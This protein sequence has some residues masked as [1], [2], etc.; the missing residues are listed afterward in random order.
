MLPADKGWVTVVIDKTDTLVN[1][2][3]IYEEL[4][5]DPTPALQQKL[6]GKLLGLPRLKKADAYNNT[7]YYRLSSSVPQPPK[8]YGLPKLHKSNIT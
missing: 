7:R 8:L 1:D 6:H 5:R 2:K 4:K 3:Q